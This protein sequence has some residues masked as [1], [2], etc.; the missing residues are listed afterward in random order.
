MVSN[1]SLIPLV[2]F[3][4]KQALKRLDLSQNEINQA[5]YCLENMLTD[6]DEATEDYKHFSSLLNK[7]SEV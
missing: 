4:M 7:L 6:Y 1:R 5:L 2:F 3:T